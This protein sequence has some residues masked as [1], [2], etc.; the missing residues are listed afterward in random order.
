[1]LKVLLADD[2]PLMLEGLCFLVDWTELGFEICGTAMDGDDALQLIQSLNPDLVITDVRMPVI[3]GLELIK[4]VQGGALQPKFIIISGYADFQYAKTAIQYGVCNYLTK[5]LDEGELESAVKNIALEIRS[6]RK[7]DAY[8]RAETAYVQTELLSQLLTREYAPQELEQTVRQ[9]PIGDDSRI[10]CMLV[11]GAALEHGN[12][13]GCR[14]LDRLCRLAE[15]QI[16]HITVLPFVIG[17]DKHGYVL[18]SG[19][20]GPEL[21]PLL[22]TRFIRC[23]RN[24]YE[25]NVTFSVSDE[26]RGP[27]SLNTVFQEAVAAGVSRLDNRHQ[28]VYYYEEEHLEQ[29]LLLPSAFMKSLTKAVV[30]GRVDELP[31]RVREFFAVISGDHASKQWISAYAANIK[32]E[33]LHEIG[34]RGGST[35]DWE[36]KWFTASQAL[37]MQSDLEKQTLTELCEAAEWFAEE[38]GVQTDQN[39]SKAIEFIRDHYPEKLK[40]HDI[41]EVLHVNA[42]YLGQRFKKK[43]G[44]SFNEYYHA[45][46]IEEA[47]KLLRRTDLNIGEIAARVGYADTDQFTA[48]FKAINGISPSVYRKG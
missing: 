46:R 16:E 10:R 34:R 5:P 47:M 18:I 3:D 14:L 20:D 42:A 38:D 41:A 40:L 4:Q 7:S 23:I 8:R 19:P 13:H 32:V 29:Q 15:Q 33:L 31:G 12:V 48:K 9:L 17:Q 1:M 25:E 21:T 26:H 24:D 35:A 22:V 30:E 44:I 6:V 28:E 43:L 2:E 36:R 37:T 27:Y 39:I 45:V 11:Y